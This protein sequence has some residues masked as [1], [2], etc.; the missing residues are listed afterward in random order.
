MLDDFYQKVV[1]YSKMESLKHDPIT[2]V[3]ETI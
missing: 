1:Q 3:A 2:Q